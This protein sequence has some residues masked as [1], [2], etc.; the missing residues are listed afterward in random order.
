MPHPALTRVPDEL[1][2]PGTGRDEHAR[3]RRLLA[4]LAANHC[5]PTLADLETERRR[6]TDERST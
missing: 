5:R 2:M 6:R 4:W 3:P 1:L